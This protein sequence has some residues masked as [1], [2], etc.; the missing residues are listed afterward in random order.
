M[1]NQQQKEAAKG[2]KFKKKTSAN[3]YNSYF[4]GGQNETFFFK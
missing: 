4:S 1:K 2:S 3:L